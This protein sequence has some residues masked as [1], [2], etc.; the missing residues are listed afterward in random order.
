MRH[1]PRCPRRT[2][3]AAPAQQVLP[4]RYTGRRSVAHINWLT[5]LAD[6]PAE[7]ANVV[8]YRVWSSYSLPDS[9]DS[10][11]AHRVLPYGNTSLY[12]GL[13]LRGRVLVSARTGAAIVV[14]MP[15]CSCSN[16]RF[17][18]G[19]SYL[20]YALAPCSPCHCIC[21]TKWAFSVACEPHR[22]CLAWRHCAGH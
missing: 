20:C 4:L 16:I 5:R 13:R 7:R 11:V 3:G 21:A 17:A 9:S 15:C 18:K 10:A 14:C 1:E 19:R 2:T 6:Q 8:S 12:S 22:L